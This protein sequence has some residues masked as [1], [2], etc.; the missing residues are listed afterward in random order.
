MHLLLHV[1]L[2]T[3]HEAAAAILMSAPKKS[4]P[5][6]N[7]DASRAPSL[8]GVTFSEAWAKWPRRTKGNRKVISKSVMAFSADGI[9]RK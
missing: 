3:S 6:E 5:G 7:M 1:F 8:K 9:L 4:A 2:P